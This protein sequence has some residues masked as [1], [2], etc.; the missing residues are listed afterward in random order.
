MARVL[1]SERTV[2]A[3]LA[4]GQPHVAVPAGA[5]VT[6]LARDTAR[7]RGVSLVPARAAGPAP[8]IFAARPHRR[9]QRDEEVP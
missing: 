6:A 5:L 4:A 2:L 3:A 8:V 1:I 9:G 7:E